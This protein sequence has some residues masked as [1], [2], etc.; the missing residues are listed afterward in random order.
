MNEIVDAKKQR[1]ICRTLMQILMERQ[2]N[3][4][5]FQGLLAV[6]TRI[7]ERLLKPATERVE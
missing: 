3:I 5:K 4:E 2:I 7:L 1:M 6:Q